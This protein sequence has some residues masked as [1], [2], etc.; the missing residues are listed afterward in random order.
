[1]EKRKIPYT[2]LFLVFGVAIGAGFGFATDQNFAVTAGIGAAVGLI[3]GA[4]VDAMKK[5]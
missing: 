5:N 2:G 4:I 3:I 1:M